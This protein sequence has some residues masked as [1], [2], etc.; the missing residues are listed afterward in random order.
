VR[1]ERITEFRGEC[2][3]L[4]RHPRADPADPFPRLEDVASSQ[5]A[6]LENLQDE[7]VSYRPDLCRWLRRHLRRCRSL[8]GTP[9]LDVDERSVG[10][11]ALG[12]SSVPSGNRDGQQGIDDLK[13]VVSVKLP[14]TMRWTVVADERAKELLPQ[15]IRPG[16]AFALLLFRSLSGPHFP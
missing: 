12:P 5:G 16:R 1:P 10:R 6:P 3:K 7:A 4:A 14:R 11:A 2:C 9:Y 13:D 8:E 15:P